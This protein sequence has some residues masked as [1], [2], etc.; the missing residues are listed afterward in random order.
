MSEEFIPREENQTAAVVP[1]QKY[2]K[3][4]EASTLLGVK[5]HVLRYWETEFPQIRPYKSKSGQ[6][7]YRR[8][9]FEALKHIHKLLY[10]ERYTIAGARQALRLMYENEAAV[11][12]EVA[13]SEEAIEAAVAQ[14]VPAQAPFVV[15]TLPEVTAPVVTDSMP[16]SPAHLEMIAAPVQTVTRDVLDIVEEKMVQ[17]QIAE[18]LG[19]ARMGLNEMIEALSA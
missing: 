15:E 10:Q 8:R 12:E 7:L 4:A 14:I 17:S 18:R 9:D 1:E 16:E 5:P 2:F 13:L 19:K 6:R 11:L 3:I